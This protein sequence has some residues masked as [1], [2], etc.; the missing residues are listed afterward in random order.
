M[1]EL[2]RDNYNVPTDHLSSMQSGYEAI[3][4]I[5]ERGPTQN[6]DKIF[7]AL[8]YNPE[9]KP[10]FGLTQKELSSKTQLEE[11]TISQRIWK[12]R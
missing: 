12:M 8:P 2:R 9:N 4:S 5:K 1:F 6:R 3:D 10:E 7:E 11:R